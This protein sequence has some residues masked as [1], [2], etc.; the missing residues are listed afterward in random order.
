MTAEQ[1]KALLQGYIKAV[2]DQQ[3][4]AAV[5]QFLAPNY[6]RHVSA[7][8]TPLTRADQK[9]L[10]T[11]FRAAFP[12]IQI[13]VE[14]MIAEGDRIAFRSTMRGTHQG[15]F[16]GIAFTGNTV[17]VGL[18]DVIRIENGKFV[19]QWG[20]PNLLDLLQQL[21]AKISAAPVDE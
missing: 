9:Q 5:D 16:Q 6:R 10:L 3:N 15:E 18:L 19:E 13:T 14:E 12:D 8:G 1:N 20:G 11:R 7:T 4:P 2:W 17:T 21:G